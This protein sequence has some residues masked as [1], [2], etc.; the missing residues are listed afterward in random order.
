[1][2]NYLRFLKDDD[3]EQADEESCDVFYLKNVNGSESLGAIDK[4]CNVK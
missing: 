4:S 1:M 2:I 3:S